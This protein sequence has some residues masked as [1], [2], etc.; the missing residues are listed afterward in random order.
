MIY[1]AL[2]KGGFKVPGV[3]DPSEIRNVGVVF[4]PDTWAASTVYY[5]QD[6][7]NYGV[8]I[9]SVFTGVYHKVITPGISGATAPTWGL[10]EGDVTLDGSQGLTWEAV[11]YNLLP[12]T[13]VVSSVTVVASDLVPVTNK[14]STA[15]GVQFTV[16]PLPDPLLVSFTVSVDATMSDGE[17]MPMTLK[18]KVANR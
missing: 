13:A 1:P 10:V 15:T 5:H 3:F 9:P 7:D 12:P 18:F 2:A 8:V 14:T 17:I 6:A 11:N 4:R 16:G